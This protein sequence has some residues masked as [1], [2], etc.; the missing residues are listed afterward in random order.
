MNREYQ[1]YILELF[2]M[3]RQ[4]TILK[5]FVSSPSDMGDE[6][7]TLKSVVEEL[8]RINIVTVR[9]ELIAWNYDVY[10]NA[11]DDAQSIIN[12]QIGEEYDIFVGILG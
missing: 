7:D 11:G 2:A 3:P 9:L 12:E 4:I 8:N 5:I 1:G 6:I 10:P